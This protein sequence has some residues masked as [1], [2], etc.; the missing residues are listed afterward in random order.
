MSLQ[1]HHTARL[2][3]EDQGLE[4]SLG[5]ILKNPVLNFF[6]NKEAENY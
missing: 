6:L 3:Q 2:R 1:C 4:A 5:Y